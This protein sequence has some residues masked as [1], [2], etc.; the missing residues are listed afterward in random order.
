MRLVPLTFALALVACGPDNPEEIPP[1]ERFYFPS[2]VVHQAVGGDAGV[3][4]VA[5][6]DFDRRYDFGAVTAVDLNALAGSATLPH[7]TYL[8]GTAGS[9]Y[10]QL[11]GTER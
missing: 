2:G 10:P 8:G 11:T 5:S 3:L 9:E 4:Y 1:I 7:P 6:S